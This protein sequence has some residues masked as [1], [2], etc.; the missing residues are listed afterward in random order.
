ML[1]RGTSLRTRE[2]G[3]TLPA[4]VVGQQYELTLQKVQEPDG[5]R[6]YKAGTVRPAAPGPMELG[7]LRVEGF[8]P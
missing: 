5:A 4:L 2:G 8:R 3:F 1:R 6:E 7:D